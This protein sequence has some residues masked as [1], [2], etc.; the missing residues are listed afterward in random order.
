MRLVVSDIPEE[1]TESE[2]DLPVKTGDQGHPDTAHVSVRI[3]RTGRKVIVEGLIKAG[4]SLR[5]G[6]CLKEF[7]HPLAID[8][9]DEYNPAEERDQLNDHELTGDEMALGT[10]EDDEIDL[11]EAVKEQVILAI[12]MKPLCSSDC[13]GI[14]PSCGQNRN[15]APCTCQAAEA[16]PRLAPL[17]KLKTLIK[18]RK[19]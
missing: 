10:Y 17:K 3:F 2:F 11:T 13:K 14:C 18:D 19:E 9:L 15:V 5:C 4:V 12:P 1:G 8:F 7:V 6:R 16:D